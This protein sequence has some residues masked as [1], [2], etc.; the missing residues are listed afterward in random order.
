MMRE[1]TSSLSL[2]GLLALGIALDTTGSNL[3]YSEVRAGKL[4][5]QHQPGSD[6]WY[7]VGFS[8]V[9]D[10][11]G[12]FVEGGAGEE[13]INYD[14][15][16]GLAAAKTQYRSVE[17]PSSGWSERGRI[18]PAYLEATVEDDDDD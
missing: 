6:F 1:S 13:D 7:D 8:S 18:D 4:D 11:W 12:S 3:S 10:A 5:L 17:R 16:I 9:T 14:N 2:V 15:F